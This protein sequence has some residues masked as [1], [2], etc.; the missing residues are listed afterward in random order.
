MN[1]FLG[2]GR[3]TRDPEISYTNTSKTIARFTVAIS[4][5]KSANGDRI[6]DFIN[7]T[8]WDKTAELI[9]NYFQ[10]GSGIIVEGQLNIDQ[11]VAD[12]GT[13]KTYTKINVARVHFPPCNSNGD[14]VPETMPAAA[15]YKTQP[16]GTLTRNDD[17]VPFD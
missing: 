6:T 5:P 2:A 14:S 10:K 7:C 11:V 1:I 13:K 4:R 15:E 16:Q 17:D 3:L 9:A 12:D 8:A